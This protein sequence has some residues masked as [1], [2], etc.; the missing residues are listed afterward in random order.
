MKRI[1]KSLLY[2]CIAAFGFSS[3]EDV[4]APYTQPGGDITHPEE[5]G[6]GNIVYSDD[7][8]GS[9]PKYTF[10]DVKL[11]EGVTYVWS[12]KNYNGAYYLNA[13]TYVGNANH[14]ANSWAVS[15]EIDLTDCTEATLT[16]EHAVNFAPDY[17][18]P[19][20]LTLWVCDNFAGDVST[21]NWQPLNIPE[22]P[23]GNSWK[24]S[25][26]GDIDLK[27]ATGK[28]VFLGFHYVSTDDCSP[29]WQIKDLKILGDGAAETP[30]NPDTPIEGTNLLPNG[31]FETWE[32]DIA[33]GW[34]SKST[35]GNA[36]TEQST[37][38]RN[39]SYA[40]LV[41]GDK[42]YNK[43]LGSTEMTLKPGTYTFKVYVKA[44]TPD[45]VSCRLGYVPILDNGQEDSQNYNY[46]PN[47][48]NNITNATWQ[49]F[50]YTFTLNQQ[51]TICLVIMNPK[52]TGTPLLIDDAELITEDGGLIEGE[53]PEP[54]LPGGDNLLTC[55]GFEE[56]NGSYP[57]G[58]KSAS[59]AS[60]ATLEQSTEA[61][62]GTY[63]VRAKSNT[64]QNKRLGSTEISLKAGTYT[65]KGYFKAATVDV[66]SACRLGYVLV[67]AGNKAGTYTYE[68]EY[69]NDLTNAE[70]TEI[71]YTFT[72]KEAQ[73][74]SLV[75][76]VP[77]SAAGDLLVDDVELTT[78][79][80]GLNESNNPDEP[81]VTAYFEQVTSITSGAQYLIVTESEGVF[82]VGQVLGETQ[83]YG[84]MPVTDATLNGSLLQAEESNAFTLKAVKG[85]YTIIDSYGR[86]L[87][88]TGTYNSFNVT[89][90]PTEGHIWTIEAQSDGTFAI[91]NP[92]VG[93]TIQFV[94]QF[95]SYGS[96]EDVRGTYPKLFIKK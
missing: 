37:D 82:K 20:N 96:Y 48:H 12:Y 67:D 8:S 63:A 33:T 10:K 53:D 13:A 62:T 3:C 46:E 2:L 65:F 78:S 40:I 69:H 93:K 24:Y 42:K 14:A 36:T 91:T 87:I 34:K 83:N 41:Q 73:T 22:Y 79:D 26:S 35:A 31:G 66:T 1:F 43:C 94:D 50:S 55:G 59:T 95:N 25:P 52:S 19:A 7:F 89:V 84:Y 90:S 47:Y 85:G 54:P 58:W 68:P 38:A 49:E 4:P 32:G 77:K 28:K 51:Q 80:G 72:L 57:T 6:N 92:S 75:V 45:V 61:R 9:K 18:L 74:V 60:S 71:S 39:G 30:D 15:P 5:P 44:A 56:W 86:Y 76:M 11:S 16:F 81:V 70:W 27:A 21:A 29:A 88:Q 23:A 64:I 17:D